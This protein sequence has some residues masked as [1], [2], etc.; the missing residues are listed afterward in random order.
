MLPRF[1]FASCLALSWLLTRAV[2]RYALSHDVIDVPNERSSH[3][4]PTPR[5]GGAAI[6]VTFVVAC[7]CLYGARIMPGNLAAALIGG[8]AAISIVGWLDDRRGLHPLVRFGVH[9]AAAIWALAWLHGMTG[10]SLGALQLHLGFIGTVVAAVFIVWCINLYNFMDGIDGIA[11]GQTVAVAGAG[12]LFI[13][14]HAA[15]NPIGIVALALAGSAAGFLIWNWAPARIFMGDTGSGFI[16]YIFGALMIASERAH[17]LPLTAWLL[18]SAVFIFDATAT[19]MRRVLRGE[20]WYSAHRQHAYQRLVQLGWS[21]GAV[22]TAVLFVDVALAALA[23]NATN[24]R[25]DVALDYVLGL[26]LVVTAYLL[27]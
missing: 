25:G 21:H 11:A 5:G 22:T 15:G 26:A 17:A 2:R 13:L 6:V 23:W 27:V 20:K 16:G 10:I 7:I 1:L 8:A 24:S 3:D 4:R 14:S 9:L 12:G 19:L 18:L